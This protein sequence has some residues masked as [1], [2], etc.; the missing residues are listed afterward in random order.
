MKEGGEHRKQVEFL[1]KRQNLRLEGQ[2]DQ[3]R[4][5]VRDLERAKESLLSLAAGG[6]VAMQR[7]QIGKGNS[8]RIYYIDSDDEAEGNFFSI[9]SED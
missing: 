5:I 7:K 6:G 3:Q 1:D 2:Y 9:V 4:V 8:G